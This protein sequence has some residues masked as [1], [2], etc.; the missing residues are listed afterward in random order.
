MNPLIPSVQAVM[1]CI[2]AVPSLALEAYLDRPR[3]PP[4]L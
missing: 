3:L 4:Q 1:Y 2:H